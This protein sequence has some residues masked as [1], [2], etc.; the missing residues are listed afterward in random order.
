MTS[1][2]AQVET[3]L[4]ISQERLRAK[5]SEF[6]ALI[7]KPMEELFRARKR[8]KNLL[9]SSASKTKSRTGRRVASEF[10]KAQKRILK[11]E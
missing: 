10:F 8:S 11:F 7:G 5:T 6:N 9:T 4:L 2:K 1:E 3:K